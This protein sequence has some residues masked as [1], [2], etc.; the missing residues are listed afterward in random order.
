[1]SK[2][3]EMNYKILS[4]YDIL[5]SKINLFNVAGVLSIVNEGT[6]NTNTNLTGI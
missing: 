1:M 6:E 4:G 2:N 5:Y 3:I